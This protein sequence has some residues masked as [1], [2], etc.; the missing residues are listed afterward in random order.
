[1]PPVL[2]AVDSPLASFLR[3]VAKETTLVPPATE[4]G[5]SALGKLSDQVNAAKNDMAK[6]AGAQPAPNASA[7]G[8]IERLVDE[9]FASRN[10]LVQGSPRTD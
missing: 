9:H 3:A 7:N 5:G 4:P 8:P 2:A 1:M 6:L 10:R